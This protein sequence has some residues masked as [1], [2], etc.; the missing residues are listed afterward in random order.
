MSKRDQK[1]INDAASRIETKTYLQLPRAQLLNANHP[2]YD[3]TVV[4]KKEENE[5][6]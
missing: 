1:M 4:G 5:S 3:V 2:R 6:L